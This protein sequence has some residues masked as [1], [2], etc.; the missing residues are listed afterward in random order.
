MVNLSLG[1]DVLPWPHDH[2]LGGG[3]VYERRL[4]WVCVRDPYRYGETVC[5]A[6]KV[7]WYCTGDMEEERRAAIGECWCRERAKSV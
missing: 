6:A 1:V 2:G 3:N 5:G 4:S 7:D